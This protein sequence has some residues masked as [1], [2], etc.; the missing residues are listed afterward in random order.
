LRTCRRR[1]VPQVGQAACGS[2]GLR[3]CG[4]LTSVGAAVFHCARRDRVLLRDIFRLG[5]ATS[6]LLSVF[7]LVRNIK[8]AERGPSWVHVLAVPV[9]GSCLGEAGTALRAQPGAVFLAQW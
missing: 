5:T 6:A 8:P 9:V 2:L 1:Y 3:H 4:Q 7:T